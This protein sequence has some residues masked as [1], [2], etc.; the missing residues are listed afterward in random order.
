MVTEGFHDSDHE[1]ARIFIAEEHPLILSAFEWCAAESGQVVLAGTHVVSAAS[2][3][4]EAV[5]AV[6]PQVL[7]LGCN[8]FDD[9]IRAQVRSLMGMG[10]RPALVVLSATV[11]VSFDEDLRKILREWGSSVALLSKAAVAGPAEFATVVQQ[12]MEGR[13]VSDSWDLTDMADCR[14]GFENA[15]DE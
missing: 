3:L 8:Q 6:Q 15:C 5:A 14:C 10:P 2:G 4:A 1:R 12:V 13:I 9:E 7:A 11:P